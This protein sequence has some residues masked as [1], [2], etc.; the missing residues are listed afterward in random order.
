MV[1][2]EVASDFTV[3]KSD[4]SIEVPIVSKGKSDTFCGK[5]DVIDNP[6]VEPEET[7]TVLVFIS[8]DSSEVPVVNSESE[9]ITELTVVESDVPFVES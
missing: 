3:V 9:I 2:F 1:E 6:I 7:T 5:S 4:G 8:K